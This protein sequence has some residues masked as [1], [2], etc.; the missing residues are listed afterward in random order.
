[1]SDEHQGNRD[2][3]EGLRQLAAILDGEPRFSNLA[4]FCRLLERGVPRQAREALSGFLLESDRWELP[5][6]R[7]A[8]CRILHLHWLHHQVHQFLAE[9]MR[10][11]LV[12]PVLKAWREEDPDALQPL[13]WTALL[14]RNPELL[15]QALEKDPADDEVRAALVAACL[16]VVMAATRQLDDGSF[17]ADE[18]AARAALDEARSLLRSVGNAERFDALH[19]GCQRLDTDFSSW[20]A[21]RRDPVGSFSD[22]CRR[23]RRPVPGQET[24]PDEA[25]PGRS[26]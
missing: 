23:H 10:Q 13:R 24:G 4:R 2:N 12:G 16:E 26:S 9:P 1:M 14:E 18:A 22:W 17:A 3:L 7:S 5:E 6:R 19:N 15:R 8:V 11:Y 20:L 21:Y 25:S